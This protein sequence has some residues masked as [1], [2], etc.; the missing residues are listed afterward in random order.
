MNNFKI[1]GFIACIV[2]V[3]GCGGNESKEEV[4]T[5][6]EEPSIDTGLSI[7][8][9][10]DAESFSVLFI[11][12]S[13]VGSNNLA[14]VISQFIEQGTGKTVT[15]SISASQRYLDERIGDGVTQSKIESTNWT[16][17]IL[18]AQKYSQ[19][20][21]I[22]YSTRGAE[23][24]ARLSKYQG[25]TPIF[26]PEH[27]QKGNSWEG[28][29]VY[30]FHSEIADNESACVAPIGPT[31]DAAL[32]IDSSLPL[33]AADGN[34]ADLTGTILTALIFYQVITGL[35]AEDLSYVESIN[36]PEDTQRLL[37]EVATDT[38]TMLGDCK[39]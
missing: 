24:W 33:H 4:I 15:T 6:D 37:R 2:I 39:F 14:G 34:H 11:G 9:N 30:D 1:L 5:P 29:Y 31:W 20:G 17:I 27:P 35:P 22:I 38:I 25:A 21:A 36:V 18:Q 26:F 19:S 13:H 16:H 7:P 28:N 3:V 10:H 8:N 12:N 32:A 23:H